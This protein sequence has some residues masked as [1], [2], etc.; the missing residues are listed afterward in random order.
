[1]STMRSELAH[2]AR[3]TRLSVL[4]ASIAHEINQPLASIITGAEATLRWLA[5]SDP[6]LEEVRELAKRVI[7]DAQRAAEIIDRIHVMAT[8]RAPK[9]TLLSL[10]NVVQESI[11]FL[12]EE[13][14]SKS[15]SVALDLVGSL[16]QIFG[17]RTQLQQVIVNLTINA[18]QAMTESGAARRDILIR[19]MLLDSETM[20]CIVEDSGPGI[21]PAHIPRLF[22]SFFTTKDA[23]MGLGLSISRSIIEAH[24]GRIRVNN[25]STMGG[26]RFSFT[27]PLIPKQG[28]C[29]APAA[30][31]ITS[32]RAC[33]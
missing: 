28:C 11:G 4:S 13:L 27:L 17:D 19:T 16:P 25:D 15:T 23:G 3:E 5:R 30:R 24:G 22:E 20:G 7:C 1:M 33:C 29:T 12:R 2:A 32:S 18:V 21:S 9:Q 6:D 31:S 26:A 10:N 14:L 8:Q